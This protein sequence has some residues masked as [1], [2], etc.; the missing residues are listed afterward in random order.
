VRV[1]GEPYQ[2]W[3]DASDV[4][5]GC[6]LTDVSKAVERVAPQGK[7]LRSPPSRVQV[8]VGRPP[9]VP[10]K[11]YVN[12]GGL[13][14]LVMASRK[15]EAERFKR[16]IAYDV[17][18]SIRKTGSYSVA[19]PEP[20]PD[21]K[22]YG[23]VVTPA[24]AGAPPVGRETSCRKSDAGEKAKKVQPSIELRAARSSTGWTSGEILRTPCPRGAR[25]R[26]RNVPH[27]AGR[28]RGVCTMRR[29]LS[30]VTPPRAR[31]R[32]RLPAPQA[33]DELAA[34][35]AGGPG[36]QDA[37][38]PGEALAPGAAPPARLDG[39]GR[40]RTFR[41]LSSPRLGLLE[42]RGALRGAT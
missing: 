38:P 30:S 9:P 11:W 33:R 13:N 20:E 7:A 27:R 24:R 29:P 3:F 28:Q 2:E 18:P 42:E 34:A 8:G 22:G 4:C 26:T 10:A 6:G 41:V 5:A 21:E 35:A 32:L 37:R 25:W 12:E 23:T 39:G 17:L 40:L 15:P 14:E 19:A 36:H 16:W 1:N 31:A